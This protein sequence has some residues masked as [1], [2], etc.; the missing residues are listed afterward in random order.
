[1]LLNVLSK[2]V[3]TGLKYK[4]MTKSILIMISAFFLSISSCKYEIATM[5][6]FYQHLSSNDFEWI[7]DTP[8]EHEDLP[9]NQ[10]IFIK[11]TGSDETKQRLSEYIDRIRIRSKSIKLKTEDEQDSFFL[12]INLCQ[13]DS[14]SGQIYP[15]KPNQPNSDLISLMSE[16]YPLKMKY[17]LGDIFD[18]HPHNIL[19]I[20]IN[21]TESSLHNFMSFLRCCININ[22]HSHGTYYYIPLKDR[23]I[24]IESFFGF[25]MC[26]I[27]YEILDFSLEYEYLS[28]ILIS[29]IYYFIPPVI[30]LFTFKPFRLMLLFISNILNFRFGV[31]YGLLIYLIEMKN[32]IMFFLKTRRIQK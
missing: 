11:F 26:L 5:E 27:L 22:S 10:T 24:R 6:T 12:K 13:N 20:S 2:L 3:K 8:I 1:M 19:D 30:F 23:L 14:D 9:P 21:D 29:L 17:K 7:Q 28:V 32:T 31:L 16:F 15:M 25:I 4:Q 18:R